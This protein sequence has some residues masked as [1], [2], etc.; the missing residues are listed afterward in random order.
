MLNFPLFCFVVGAILI[1]AWTSFIPGNNTCYTIV[2]TIDGHM[3][4]HFTI[5]THWNFIVKIQPT[6][7]YT[8]RYHE[9]S[10]KPIKMVD[11]TDKYGNYYAGDIKWIWS[12]DDPKLILYYM[13]H[14]G[15]DTWEAN[16]ATKIYHDS[17]N[18][19]FSTLSPSQIIFDGY[20]LDYSYRDAAPYGFTKGT[21]IVDNL[22]PRDDKITDAVYSG[23]R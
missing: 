4:H 11:I 13:K 18:E 19:Y 22:T 15:P 23:Y 21:R 7:I 8:Y 20:P 1:V 2:D 12:C 6:N 9:Q 16:L 14:L 17:I 3:E 5:Y 10:S